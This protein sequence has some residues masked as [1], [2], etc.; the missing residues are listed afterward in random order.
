ML[1]DFSIS[2][3]LPDSFVSIADKK[4]IVKILFVEFFAFFAVLRLLQEKH[5][6]AFES[7]PENLVFLYSL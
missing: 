5:D 1:G 2:G 4:K 7:S 6:P 3:N